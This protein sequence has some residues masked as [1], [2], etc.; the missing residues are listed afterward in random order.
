MIKSQGRN[1]IKNGAKAETLTKQSQKMTSEAKF[2]VRILNCLFPVYWTLNC[3][4]FLDFE[5]CLCCLIS[6][7]VKLWIVFGCGLRN[8][9]FCV[10]IYETVKVWMVFVSSLLNCVFCVCIFGTVTLWIAFVSGLLNYIFCVWI[11]QGFR[12]VGKSS[13]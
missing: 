10:W 13:L 11:S 1:E 2:G 6:E 7:S 9:V 5:L 12:W 4:C 3:V 8:Y